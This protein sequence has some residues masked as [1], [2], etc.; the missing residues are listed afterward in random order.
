[1]SINKDIFNKKFNLLDVEKSLL[2]LILT[3]KG[4]IDD[5]SR[6][7]KKDDF[8]NGNDTVN[9]TV[10]DLCLRCFD[11]YRYVS[12]PAIIDEIKNSG[13]IR[14]TSVANM[15]ISQY[16]KSLGI[17]IIRDDN[18]IGLANILKEASV[19]RKIFIAT[20]EI[21]FNL[22]NTP[23]DNPNKSVSNAE[24]IFSECTNKIDRGADRP[25]N[26]YHD[27]ADALEETKNQDFSTKGY[28]CPYP[29]VQN[30]FGSLTRPGNI[31][32]F[33]SRSGV[34]KALANYENVRM[35]D[36]TLKR[37]CDLKIGDEVFSIKG[38]KT[39]VAGV[40]PQGR[41]EMIRF[42]WEDGRESTVS[43]YDH[44]WQVC[45]FINR[46]KKIEVITSA[47]IARRLKG[48]EKL[49]IPTSYFVK[50]NVYGKAIR[51]DYILL[52]RYFRDGKIEDEEYEHLLNV[53]PDMEALKDRVLDKIDFERFPLS[54]RMY[55]IKEYIKENP[56][57]YIRRSDFNLGLVKDERLGTSYRIKFSTEDNEY[58]NSI[59]K[60]FRSV[61]GV[62][63]VNYSAKQNKF[64]VVCFT[65]K[66][67]HYKR[68]KKV[69][70]LH[71]KYVQDYIKLHD[72]KSI[73]KLPCTCILVKDPSHL[74]LLENNVLT[75]NTQITMD[76]ATKVSEQY[77]VPILHFD[78][79]EMSERELQYRRLSS[80]SGVNYYD[81]ESG[82]WCQSPQNV[83][84]LKQALSMVH[85]KEMF[86]Y[87]VAGKSY[88]EMRD[89]IKSFYENVCKGG[90]MIFCFDYMK[91]SQ[92]GTFSEQEH[93]YLGRL[94]DKFKTLIHDEI[95]VDRK[96]VISMLTS[97]Q[98]NK[99]GI[100][101]KKSS[102]EMEDSENVFGLSDRLIHYASHCAILRNNTND[103]FQFQGNGF[104]THK[105]IFIKGRFLGEDVGGYLNLVQM[106]DGSLRKNSINLEFNNFSVEEKGDLR[107]IVKS[108][109]ARN[110]TVKKT[111]GVA[112]PF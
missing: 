41:K 18:H 95:K 102:N 90:Q 80:L 39:R 17:M 97:V 3:R 103:E 23:F 85:G 93:Q 36:G 52:G 57:F 27:I 44:L 66:Y 112:V 28:P 42:Y 51:E 58:A 12:I 4:V 78:N 14:L 98:S 46:R 77:N 68:A 99:L 24:K 109:S 1:M 62:G 61:G 92:N 105:L 34:G 69:R 32:L 76:I 56:Q 101:A 38:N 7:L 83:A 63:K 59:I 75:H 104:G 87:Q 16:I 22:L 11:R 35:A 111:S 81:I 110:T 91:P 49:Y 25:V 73:G 15:D 6:I 89:L 67:G 82:K 65:S 60:L 20:S 106:P 53:F 31:T 43:S 54:G 26:I 108:F 37:I 30:I 50:K 72:A 48:G 19:R 70:G 13:I 96:P 10:Y 2:A 9:K 100:V 84:K 8:E 79:G 40:F 94:M 64:E 55:F 5:V 47:E 33:T 71:S 86:Y 29:T 74:F 107:D 21:Q 45:S 88:D